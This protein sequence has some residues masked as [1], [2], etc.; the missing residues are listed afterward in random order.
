MEETLTT[1]NEPRRTLYSPF[2][3][4]SAE[5]SSVKEKNTIVLTPVVTISEMV[6]GGPTAPW[7]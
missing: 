3:L 6:E 2:S 1:H 5:Y 7:W 4:K